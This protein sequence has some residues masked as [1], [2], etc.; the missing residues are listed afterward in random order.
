MSKIAVGAGRTSVDSL[1]PDAS[2]HHRFIAFSQ[3]KIVCYCC[4]RTVACCRA[5][6]L[7][8]LMCPSV[9]VPLFTYLP[10]VS[11]TGLVRLKAIQIVK[12]QGLLLVQSGC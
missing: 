8:L 6:V 7:E 1:Q 3:Q 12:N 5:T 10:Y 2:P 4:T 11:S 9:R